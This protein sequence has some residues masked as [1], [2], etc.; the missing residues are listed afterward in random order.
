[1]DI[2]DKTMDVMKNFDEMVET[3]RRALMGSMGYRSK[4]IKKPLVGVIHGYNQMSPGNF[5]NKQIVEGAKIAIAASGG[6]PVEIPIP[7]VCGSMSGGAESFRYNFPYRDAAAALAELLMSIN[8]LDACMF[9]PTCDNVVPAYLLAA[10][11]V[12]IPAIFVTGGYMRTGCYGGKVLTAF[13]IPKIIAGMS[14]TKDGISDREIEQIIEAACPTTGACPEIGTANTMAAATEALG[15][16]LPGNTIIAATDAALIR[17]A[18]DAAEFL[19][20]ELESDLRPRDIVTT[21]ALRD[22]A[23]V[24]LALGGSPNVLLHLLALSEEVKGGLTLFEWDRLSRETPLLCRIK[25]NHPTNT[26]TEFA[27]AGGVYRV[28]GELLP[29]L[30]SDRKMVMNIS[31][32]EAINRYLVTSPKPNT[33]LDVI[34]SINAP[35]SPDG[36]LMVLSGNLAPE[37]AVVKTSAVSATMWDFSGPAKVYDSEFRAAQALFGGEVSE[38]E[39]VVVRYEGPRGAPGARELMLLMH[40]IVGMGLAEKVAVVTDGRFSGTNLG[41][42]VG[43]VAPEAMVGGLIS[44]VQ[45]G[46]LIKIDLVNRKL[47]LLVDA[48]ELN[49][50]RSVWVKPEPKVKSGLLYDWALR[51]GSLAKGGALG[52]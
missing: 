16:S 20:A 42:A 26:M 9:I 45:D 48:A 50:R 39:V 7:G 51:G 27:Q 15:L 11:R 5:S 17:M 23:R 29:L 46:D 22:A 30:E 36:G 49:L 37:G 4:D 47:E 32:K 34:C 12:N 19:L 25:P 43:H 52:Q 3:Y 8:R 33:D 10:V 1:M 28:M 31:M 13:D 44:L 38:G 14:Q 2:E 6:T 24:V 35:V 40:A 41:L 21:E 18:K